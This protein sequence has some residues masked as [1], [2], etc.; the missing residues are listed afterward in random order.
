MNILVTGGYGFIGANFILYWLSKFPNDKVINVDLC[1]YAAVKLNLKN[2]EKSNRYFMVKADIADYETMEQIVEQYEVDYIVNFA[3]ESHN[4]NSI[5]NPTAFYK[6]NL[7]GLQTLMEVVRNNKRIKRIHHISTCEVYGDMELDSEQ[8]FDENSPLGGNSPYSSSKA[9]AQ[10]AAKAYFKTYDIPITVSVCSNNYGPYQFPEKLIPLFVTNMLEGKPLTLYAESYYKRE[11]LHVEDHCR[12]IETILLNGVNGEIYNIGSGI[13]KS[14]DEI[15]DII[16]TYFGKSEEQKVIV[17]SR[18]AHDRR[19]LLNSN[20]IR[21]DLL[22]EPRIDFD[23]GIISTIDWYV[24]NH[25]WW[26]PLLEKRKV[27]EKSW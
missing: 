14:V 19:Y 11:W 12:A 22:W 1:T 16:L 26:K 2:V 21:K 8:S 17:P 5:I 9:C 15:A 7:L 18:P 4:S 20:K 13:E 10:L 24:N 3:A 6:T 27:S 23:S 25:E